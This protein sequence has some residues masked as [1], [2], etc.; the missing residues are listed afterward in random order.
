MIKGNIVTDIANAAINVAGSTHQ[1]EISANK[2]SNSKNGVR[3]AADAYGRNSDITVSGDNTISGMSVHAVYAEQDA[4]P[5]DDKIVV[6]NGITLTDNAEDI[7]DE[8]DGAQIDDQRIPAETPDEGDGTTDTDDDKGEGNEGV[9]TDTPDVTEPV[10]TDD[11]GTVSAP[12]TG[13]AAG[14][15]AGAAEGTSILVTV[16]TA[17]AMLAVLAGIRIAAKEND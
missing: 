1:V 11:D 8:E 17:L 3:V 14:T 10:N 2:L 4:I 16:T 12:N 15:A 5:D 7:A 13:V 6:V 9:G